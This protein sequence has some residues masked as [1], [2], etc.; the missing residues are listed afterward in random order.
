MISSFV[1]LIIL[2]FVYFICAGVCLFL[3]SNEND[4]RV[5]VCVIDNFF[6]FSVGH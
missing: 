2:T 5:V 1:C 4:L 3:L 6:R